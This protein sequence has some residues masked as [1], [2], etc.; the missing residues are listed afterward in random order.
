MKTQP[1]FSL[2]YCMRGRSEI[3]KQDLFRGGKKGL[4]GIKLSR[5]SPSQQTEGEM[6]G[7]PAEFIGQ[8]AGCGP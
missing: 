1:Y 2:T 4:L 8:S 6:V 7:K 3:T 5:L